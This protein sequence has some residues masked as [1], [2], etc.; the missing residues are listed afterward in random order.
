MQA[1]EEPGN[2]ISRAKAK[3]ATW[4]EQRDEQNRA[5]RFD[6]CTASELIAIAETGKTLDGTKLTIGDRTALN[7]AWQAMFGEPLGTRS[8]SAGMTDGLTEPSLDYHPLL[9][10]PDDA[11]LRPRDITRICGIPRTTLKRWRRAGTFPKP[12]R[13][14][15]H[16]MHIGW[17]ARQVKAWLAKRA[18]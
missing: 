2:Y 15:P 18:A 16:A 1:D 10:V 11:T 13:L 9:S 17:P 6:R 7:G 4:R 3:L 12:Q 5:S 8:N 14:S